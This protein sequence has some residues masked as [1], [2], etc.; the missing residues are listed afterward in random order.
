ML[1][2]YDCPH[3]I[4]SGSTRVTGPMKWRYNDT[5][6]TTTR[7]LKG[8]LLT[9]KSGDLMQELGIMERQKKEKKKGSHEDRVLQT[10]WT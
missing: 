7:Q 9:I 8:T 1:R 5:L 2:A 4:C 10:L 3:L 6:E